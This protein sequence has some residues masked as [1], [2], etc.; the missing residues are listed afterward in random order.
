VNLHTIAAWKL[1]TSFR[2]LT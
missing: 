2:I 1:G